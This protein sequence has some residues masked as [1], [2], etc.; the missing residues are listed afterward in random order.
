MSLSHDDALN[1]HTVGRDHYTLI[2]FS[3]YI[4]TAFTALCYG[5]VRYI[6]MALCR[7]ICPPVTS[8]CSTKTAKLRLTNKHHTMPW[9]L[10]FRSLSNPS[11]PKSP[12]C[13]HSVSP[14]II[15]HILV[16]GGEREIK[17]GKWVFT[18]SSSLNITNHSG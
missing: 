15:F 3:L 16:M 11:Y 4:Y 8:G 17:F 14:F 13:P 1:T 6:M 9:T 10:V 18:A 5:I 7:A 12:H 2:M